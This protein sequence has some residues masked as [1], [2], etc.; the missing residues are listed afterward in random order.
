MEEE[1]DVISMDFPEYEEEN[2]PFPDVKVDT[3]FYENREEAYERNRLI[4]KEETAEEREEAFFANFENP[5]PGRLERLRMLMSR[6]LKHG[7]YYVALAVTVFA[8]AIMWLI[9]A[10]TDGRI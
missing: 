3:S 8:S 1:N 7:G 9:D 10:L 5:E 4:V 6:N 2:S